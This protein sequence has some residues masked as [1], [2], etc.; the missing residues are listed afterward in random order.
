MEATI[1]SRTFTLQVPQ[2][3]VRFLSA[4]AKKMGW[5]KKEQTKKKCGLDAALK[6]VEKGN[7]KSFDNMDSLM[8]YLH[9]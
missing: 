3:D 8:D 1:N 5:T 6:E 7:L 2:S 4:L 9:S